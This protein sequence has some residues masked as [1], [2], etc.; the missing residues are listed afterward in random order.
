METSVVVLSST[1]KIMLRKVSRIDK[2]T[3]A[4]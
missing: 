3:D 1:E 4:E 2:W